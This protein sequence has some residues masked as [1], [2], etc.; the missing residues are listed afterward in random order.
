MPLQ[1]Y[2]VQKLEIQIPLTGLVGLIYMLHS[3]MKRLYAYKNSAV[4]V[5][6]S[7]SFSSRWSESYLQS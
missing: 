1:N 5:L 7:S 2:N 3:K 4:T 6:Q